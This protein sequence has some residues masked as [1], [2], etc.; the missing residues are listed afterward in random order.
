MRNI[1]LFVAMTILMAHALVAHTHVPQSVTEEHAALHQ[2]ANSLLDYLE[3]G[4]H[5]EAYDGAM[6]VYQSPNDVKPEIQAHQIAFILR[7]ILNIP[8]EVSTTP[9]PLTCEKSGT[10]S[11]LYA[12]ALSR[13]GPPSQLV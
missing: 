1:L 9:L 6:E 2:Q 12:S 5:H 7:V 3:L 11:F 10:P 4:F 13:R 8:I